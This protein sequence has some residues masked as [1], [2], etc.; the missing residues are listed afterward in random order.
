MIVNPS[1]EV[2]KLIGENQQQ[3]PI[4]QVSS[5]GIQPPRQPFSNQQHPQQQ[6]QPTTYIPSKYEV[7]KETTFTI[8]FKL[9]FLDDRWIITETGSE[10]WVKFRMWNYTEEITW[11]NKV[12]EFDPEKRIHIINNDKFNE[13]KIR[14]LLIDW[15]LA[16]D[17][18]N[19]KLIHVNNYLVDESYNRFMLLQPN[20]VHFIINRMN[21]I[22]E[23]NA[24]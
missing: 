14:N 18:I 17:D 9:S 4:T 3:R 11:K 5:N 6:N 13:F 19:L 20:L 16:A 7:T 21:S 8:R 24:V 15:S 12:T 23:N 22:L 1:P 10:Q 2:L